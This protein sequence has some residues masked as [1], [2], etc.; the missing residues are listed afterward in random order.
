MD[1]TVP[2]A[3][4]VVREHKG[5][6]FY[7]AKFRHGT[8][9]IK[10]RV[11]PAWLER[12]HDT[13]RPRKGRMADGYYDERRAHVKAAELVAAHLAAAATAAQAEEERSGSGLTFRYLA[14]NYLDWLEAIKGAKPATLRD[15]RLL[16]AG[17]PSDGRSETRP[18]GEIMAALGDARVRTISQADVRELLNSVATRGVSP[19]TVNKH[20]NLIGAIFSYGVRERALSTNPVVGIDRRREPS[21]SALLYYQPAEIE[22]LAEAL[23]SGLH[24]E[25]NERH[26][27]ACTRRSS[28]GCNCRPTFSVF[29]TMRRRARTTA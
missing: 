14:R 24:R 19:R 6:P 26:S 23:A 8:T 9:Q 22:S 27:R 28:T 4:L 21:R 13:W 11:G 20:R 5:R 15:H 17:V 7:E 10:R 2:S 16:L 1:S 29:G 12:D 25:V 18:D 3:S